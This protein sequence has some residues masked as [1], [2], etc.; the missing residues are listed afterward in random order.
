[1]I[2]AESGGI[3]PESETSVFM[4]IIDAFIVYALLTCASQVMWPCPPAL[5]SC[6]RLPMK[7]LSS[8]KIVLMLWLRAVPLLFPGRQLPLQFLPLRLLL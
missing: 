1:M 8:P 7:D 3:H 4:Q 5:P 6:Y 2:I